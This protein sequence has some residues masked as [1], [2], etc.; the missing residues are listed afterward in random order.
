[1]A[2]RRNNPNTLLAG[3]SSKYP[4]SFLES[5]FSILVLMKTVEKF[6]IL[7]CALTLRYVI[8]LNNY[9]GSA[10]SKWIMDRTGKIPNVW[11][12]GSPTALDGDYNK[13]CC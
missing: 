4:S 2:E 6:I 1:M 12:H 8:S 9:S 13:P 10:T 11:R 5:L 7:F 3:V